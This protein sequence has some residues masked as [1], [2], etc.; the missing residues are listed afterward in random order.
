MWFKTYMVEDTQFVHVGA[1]GQVGIG[2][3]AS[4]YALQLSSDSA[5]KPGTGTWTVASDARLK[6][7]LRPFT[8]GL[9]VLEGID[10][11]RY[12]YNGLA[13]TPKDMEAI[14]VVAQDIRRVAPY[15]VGTFRAKLDER[16]EVE[17]DLLDFNAHALTFVM[18]NA[19]K[20]LNARTQGLTA[21]GT[22]PPAPPG[23]KTDPNLIKASFDPR[24][25]DARPPVSAPFAPPNLLVLHPV[26]ADVKLGDVLVMNPA[27]G[28][29]LYKCNLPADPMVV[30]IVA[31]YEIGV[32]SSELG[33]QQGGPALQAASYELPVVVGGVTLVKADATLA[34]IA[35]GDLLATSGNPGHA[36]KAQRPIEPGTVVGKA[37]EDLPAGTGLIRVLVM[38]R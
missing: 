12:R 36:M 18:I 20:E 8:D 23:L 11:V 24:E 27:N 2:T 34:P 6:K 22:T 19:I 29:E 14:G 31:G 3:Y 21:T 16:A 25:R 17:T 15:T 5:A 7:D 35:K 26:M 38:L 13:G 1:D 28:E 10:P 4:S 32:R 30:G 37:L 9:A 33:E